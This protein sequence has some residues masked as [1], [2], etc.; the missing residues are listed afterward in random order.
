MST[1]VQKNFGPQIE[2][3]AVGTSVS[4]ELSES[5]GI[6]LGTEMAIQYI[7]D[8]YINGVTDSIWLPSIYI[9]C[10]CQRAIVIFVK[11][12]VGSVGILKFF[13]E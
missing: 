1:G 6:L 7:K 11:D 4:S 2:T 10:D 12:T 3:H 5:E 9:F 13:K 8:T